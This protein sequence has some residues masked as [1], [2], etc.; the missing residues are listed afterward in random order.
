MHAT[1][2]CALPM[3]HRPGSLNPPH[4]PDCVAEL[5]AAVQSLGYGLVGDD[6]IA[7]MMAEMDRDGD[8]EAPSCTPQPAREPGS[9]GSEGGREGCVSGSC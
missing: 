3:T 1:M 7:E 4:P 8:G 6:A 9:Q 5:K 2:Q